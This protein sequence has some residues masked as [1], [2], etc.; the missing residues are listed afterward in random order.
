VQLPDDAL[1]RVDHQGQTAL[2]IGRLVL[3][4]AGVDD[5]A[6]DAR[7]EQWCGELAGRY[8]ELLE[9]AD[10]SSWAAAPHAEEAL[11]RLDGAGHRLALLTGNPET[12]ARARVER[13]GLARFFPP[14][15]GAFGC[16]REAR[17][18][19]IGLA[20]AR[21]GDWP[22]EA[23][24]E[25]GDTTVDAASAREAGIRSLLVGHGM[26]LPDALAQLG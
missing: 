15:Q 11:S 26:S 3:R 14:G 2:R 5:G 6:I 17:T 9:D 12:I 8:L 16:E 7:L 19:L 13:L 23:T 1:E 18:E 10:T 20:R 24:V 22:R 25:V 21:A 4:D